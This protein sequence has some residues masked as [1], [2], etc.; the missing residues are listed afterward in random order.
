M[1]EKKERERQEKQRRNEEEIQEE[2]RIK[3]EV[4]ELN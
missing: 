4:Q 2:Y 3:K 1:K